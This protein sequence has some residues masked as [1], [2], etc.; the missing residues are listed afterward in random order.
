VEGFLWGRLFA[1][2]PKLDI[3]LHHPYGAVR[4]PLGIRAL[5]EAPL[6]V[7]LFILAFWDSFLQLATIGILGQAG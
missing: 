7:N 2:V 1:T 6:P 5:L 3:S 4:E